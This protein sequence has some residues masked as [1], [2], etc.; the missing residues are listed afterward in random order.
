MVARVATL[1]SRTYD[2]QT[3]LR[4]LS[5]PEKWGPYITK[6]NSVQ[7]VLGARQ[8]EFFDA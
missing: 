1:L 6:L 8:P 2:Y 5:A 3:S 4:P 7:L